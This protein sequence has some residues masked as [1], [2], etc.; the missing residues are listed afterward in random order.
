MLN[1]ALERF[2]TPAGQSRLPYHTNVLIENLDKHSL[3]KWVV[4]N[5]D[6]FK[7]VLLED[8]LYLQGKINYTRLY[9]RQDK[10]LRP[11]KIVKKGL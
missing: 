3:R 7:V 6:G 10:K 9:L 5:V 4:Q 1:K 2:E 8:I 11:N